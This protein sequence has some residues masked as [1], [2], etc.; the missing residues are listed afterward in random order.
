[1]I[2]G[3]VPLREEKCSNSSVSCMLGNLFLPVF[4]LNVFQNCFWV[5]LLHGTQLRYTGA[6]VFGLI[7]SPCVSVGSIIYVAETFQIRQTYVT[8]TFTHALSIR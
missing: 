6:T 8:S 4:P 5:G 7:I 2:F 3:A 1:M